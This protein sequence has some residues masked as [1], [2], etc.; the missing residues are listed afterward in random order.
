MSAPR[1]R[2]ST[3]AVTSLSPS[4]RASCSRYA[5]LP[6]PRPRS[7]PSCLPSQTRHQSSVAAAI[8]TAKHMFANAAPSPIG[9]DPLQSVAK[10]LKFL[11][12][13]IQQLLGSGHPMLDTVAKYYTQSEGKYV[14]PMLVLLMSQATALT[15]KHD[16][17]TLKALDV[18]TPMSPSTVLA[19]SN[20]ES[21]LTSPPVV[22]DLS[23][24]SVL[25]SQR[26]L[27]EITEL[28]HTASLL[29]DDV[30]DNSTSRRSAPSANIQFGNKMAVLAGDFM[31]GR[32]SVALARLRDPEVTELLAT[33][34]ANLI[35]G[36]FM[37]LK[38]TASD[39][40]HPSYSQETME[41][42]LQK[43]YLKSASLIS[44]STRA[45]AILGNCSPDVVEAAYSYGKNLGLAFQLVDDMLDYT[46]SG[47]ELGKP[48]GADLELGLATA[49]L[50]FAWKDNKELGTLVGRRF[51][52]EGD[53][54]RAHD[55]VIQGNGIEQTRAM[56]EDYINKAREAIAFFPESQ[57]KAGL[58]DMCTK[59]LQRRK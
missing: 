26:R 57:A 13:N 17:P 23:D 31:L 37:Q 47:A 25:P 5:H 59:V 30:I 19:D 41:Y 21:P 48:A 51:A 16:R 12:G 15:L 34:I 24:T 7:I 9:Y 2:A 20:P 35:E 18:D 56:A 3:L 46:V 58:L 32:A 42:Y 53:V 28:I 55:L 39:A 36:E 52:E 45:A 40:K 29:H 14:R 33:V 27:A 1:A 50:L 22:E 11:T 10:E 4:Y 38:N 8:Q 6:P 44:K 49:P 43:T 54:K